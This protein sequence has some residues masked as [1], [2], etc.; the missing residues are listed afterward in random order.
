MLYPTV[1]VKKPMYEARY[2]TIRIGMIFRLLSGLG[3]SSLISIG[4]RFSPVAGAFVDT[5]G[6]V[7]RGVRG[8]VTVGEA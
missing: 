2:S 8:A 5:A 4:F 7:L 6:I 3:E 1:I